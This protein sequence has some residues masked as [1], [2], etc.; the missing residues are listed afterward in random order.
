M[1]K[2]TTSNF[3]QEVENS[4]MP[5]LVDFWAEWCGPCK[6]F[7]PI[8]EELE[9]EYA[10]KL[11]MGKVNV[12]EE[13]E[14]A[15]QFRIMGIPTLVLLKDGKKIASSTGVLSKADLDAWLKEHLK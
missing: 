3:V 6:Q 13:Q 8:L 2:L 10:D 1:L 14:L 7:A 5:V 4:K 11:K 9:Q 12:D 15:I